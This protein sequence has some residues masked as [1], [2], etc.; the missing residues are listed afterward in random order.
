MARRAM[1]DAV[2]ASDVRTAA[3]IVMGSMLHNAVASGEVTCPV[4]QDLVRDAAG[5]GEDFVGCIQGHVIHAS[6]ASDLLLGGGNCPTCRD[7]LFRARGDSLIASQA[8]TDLE[9][10]AAFTALPKRPRLLEPGDLVVVSS[11]VELC[12]RS[13][14]SHGG[15][16]DVKSSWFGRT[17]SPLYGRKAR[18]KGVFAMAESTRVGRIGLGS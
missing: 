6:C 16:N 7:S 2:A 14:N 3:E 12:R 1:R 4:C 18:Q 11:D 10:N 8:R 9:A 17:V 15:W 13:N 5:P